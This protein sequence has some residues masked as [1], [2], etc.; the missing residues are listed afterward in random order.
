MIAG[1][2]GSIAADLMQSDLR[3]NHNSID[4]VREMGTL[5]GRMNY[6]FYTGHSLGH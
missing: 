3:K 1:Q 2:L 6:N 5:F 4:L